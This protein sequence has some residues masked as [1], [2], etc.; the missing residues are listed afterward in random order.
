MHVEN[1][2]TIIPPKM[3]FSLLKSNGRP[4]SVFQVI[5]FIVAHSTQSLRGMNCWRVLLLKK[6]KKDQNSEIRPF[7]YYFF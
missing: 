1:L 3:S 5:Y 4:Y 6:K 2:P 7:I